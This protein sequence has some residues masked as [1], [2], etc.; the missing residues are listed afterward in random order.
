MADPSR[1]TSPQNATPSAEAEAQAIL[2]RVAG[3]GTQD[4]GPAAPRAPGTDAQPPSQQN[5]PPVLSGEVLIEHEGATRTVKAEDLVKAFTE[6]SDLAAQRKVVRGELEQLAAFKAIESMQ[7]H[8]TPERQQAFQRALA[9]PTVLDH[10][11]QGGPP[12][13]QPNGHDDGEPDPLDLDAR[14]RQRPANQPDPVQDQIGQL[15][16]AVSLLL[17]RANQQEQQTARTS[18]ADEVEGKLMSF[19]VFKHDPEARAAA[20][21]NIM[22]HMTLYP[23]ASLEKV[24]AKRAAQTQDM[25]QRAR[26]GSPRSPGGREP[27]PAPSV[28]AGL[29]GRKVSAAMEDGSA[30]DIAAAIVQ[31]QID[32]MTAPR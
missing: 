9:D 30:V 16:R 19:S 17:N 26:G 22:D 15:T 2:A 18:M 12:P 24:V 11:G 5:D 10:L 28:L 3:G 27:I 31:Q 29:D 13:S 14:P 1:E 20:K 4:Q 23:D 6:A 21:E 7:E 25:I 32:R 8:W